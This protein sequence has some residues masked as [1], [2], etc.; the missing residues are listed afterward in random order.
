M[1]KSYITDEPAVQRAEANQFDAVKQV[2]NRLR[3]LEITGNSIV[4]CDVRVIGG[5]WSVYPREYQE[6]FIRNIYDAHTTFSDLRP[7]IEGT[8]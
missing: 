5:T 2:Q 4:K 8:F 6:D 3:A 1:P 7:F